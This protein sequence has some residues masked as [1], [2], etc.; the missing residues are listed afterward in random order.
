VQAYAGDT[1][2]CGSE[3]TDLEDGAGD[4]LSG[5]TSMVG[6][7]PPSVNGWSDISTG[8]SEIESGLSTCAEESWWDDLKS[9]VVSAFEDL[10][11]EVKLVADS[12]EIIVDGENI[13]DNLKSAYSDC[14]SGAWESCG[15]DMGNLVANLKSSGVLIA[16][17]QAQSTSSISSDVPAV[18]GT[19]CGLL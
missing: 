12:Y 4:I 11:P 10:V 14:Q 3:L 7:S 13:Y 5:L 15:S 16:T 8:F 19:A 17:T 1:M 18:V 9:D 2:T 6:S